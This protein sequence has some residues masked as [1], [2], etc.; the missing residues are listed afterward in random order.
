VLV[1]LADA[2]DQHF[3]QLRDLLL[4]HTRDD[5]PH[6]AGLDDA[7]LEDKRS[8]RATVRFTELFDRLVRYRNT[9]SS[10]CLTC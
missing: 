1:V 9:A 2:A 4:G 7:V 6:A 10:A 5:F 3:V 8:V